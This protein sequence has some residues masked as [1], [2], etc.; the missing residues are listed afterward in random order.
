MIEILKTIRK[1]FYSRKKAKKS[2]E[3]AFFLIT[4]EIYP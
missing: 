2:V 1:I 3:I 4:R